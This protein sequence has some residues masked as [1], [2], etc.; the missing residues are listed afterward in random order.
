MTISSSASAIEDHPISSGP[1]SSQDGVDA[2]D[3]TAEGEVKGKGRPR[4]NLLRNALSVS[5]VLD[6]QPRR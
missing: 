1:D 2:D 5:I 6:P 3:D 4:R